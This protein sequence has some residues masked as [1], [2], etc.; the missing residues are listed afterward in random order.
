MTANEYLK[1][2][3]YDI[4]NLQVII[5]GLELDY[6]DDFA[7]KLFNAIYDN[8]EIGRA[9]YVL[10]YALVGYTAIQLTQAEDRKFRQILDE[11]DATTIDYETFMNEKAKTR[12][13]IDSFMQNKTTIEPKNQIF[14]FDNEDDKI[15]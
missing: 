7:H 3:N 4:V 13:I 8:K 9:R 11:F 10:L 1:T 2:V 5:R 14:L 6:D 15:F 12:E